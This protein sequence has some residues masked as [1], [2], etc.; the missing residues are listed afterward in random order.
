MIQWKLGF[1]NR[2]QKRQKQ[3][4]ARPGVE[5]YHWFILQ[6]LLATPTMQFSLVSDGVISRISVLLL[7]LSVWFS[8]DRIAL[9]F[10]LRLRLRLRRLWKPALKY[11][12]RER[13]CIYLKLLY[14]SFHSSLV[15]SSF[16]STCIFSSRSRLFSFI[17]NVSIGNLSE[18]PWE[19][20][21]RTRFSFRNLGRKKRKSCRKFWKV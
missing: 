4:I 19:S 5:H 15:A 1:R 9:R 3:P 2:K 21:I 6:L 20:G 8:L 18:I 17:I 11:R 14:G 10:W 12:L 13:M 7:T 16:S